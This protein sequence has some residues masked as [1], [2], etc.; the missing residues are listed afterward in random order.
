ME[1]ILLPVLP[2]VLCRGKVEDEFVKLR[3]RILDSRERSN[4]RR[5]GW[6]NRK[7]FCRA[8]AL[9]GGKFDIG[10]AVGVGGAGE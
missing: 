9:T 2:V 5:S 6:G 7:I 3:G 8:E 10:D 1:H 4:T